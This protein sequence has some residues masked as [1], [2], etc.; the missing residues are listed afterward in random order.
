MLK[1][2]KSQN[3]NLIKTPLLQLGKAAIAKG[4][5]DYLFIG[6]A[7]S[8]PISLPLIAGLFVAYAGVHYFERKGNVAK[9]KIISDEF[10]QRFDEIRSYLGKSRKTQISEL[11]KILE[12]K[13]KQ[14]KLYD[15]IAYL[16]EETNN[17][18]T[19]FDDIFK[20]INLLKSDFNDF[21]IQLE[22]HLCLI[23]KTVE[24]I[25]ETTSRTELKIDNS[26]KEINVHISDEINKLKDFIGNEFSKISKGTATNINAPFS[27]GYDSQMAEQLEKIKQ[28]ETLIAEVQVNKDI[29]HQNSKDIQDVSS[30]RNINTQTNK[31]FKEKSNTPKNIFELFN[32][33]KIQMMYRNYIDAMELSEGL[34]VYAENLHIDDVTPYIQVLLARLTINCFETGVVNNKKQLGKAK[35]LLDLAEKN[36]TSD[37]CDCID[38]LKAIVIEFNGTGTVLDLLKDKIN[39]YA[40]RAR[41]ASLTANKKYSEAIKLIEEQDSIHE[42]WSEVALLAYVCDG[43]ENKAEQ[44]LEEIKSSSN[45]SLFIICSVKYAEILSLKITLL[46]LTHDKKYYN[47]IAEKILNLL[48][49]VLQ[50]TAYS[51]NIQGVFC[52]ANEMALKAHFIKGN[53]EEIKKYSNLLLPQTPV[54]LVVLESIIRQYIQS[55]PDILTRIR[56]EHKNNINAQ[57]LAVAIQLHCLNEPAE[58]FIAFKKVVSLAKTEHEKEITI[59]CLL[60]LWQN[61]DVELAEDCYDLAMNLSEPNSLSVFKF[62]AGRYLRNNQPD[63]VLELLKEQPETDPVILQ[64]KGNAYLQKKQFSDAGVY[65]RKTAELVNSAE[66]Y[67]K[68]GDFYLQ[69]NIEREAI[70]CYEKSISLQP[71]NIV[72]R[73]NLAD[74]YTRTY[75]DLKKAIEHLLALNELKP[76]DSKVLINIAT[77]YGRLFEAEKSLKYYDK[78]CEVD[79]PMLE[80]V[81][82]KAELLTMIKR[83]DEAFTH[84]EFFKELFQNDPDFLLV[85]MNA[86]HY[87]GF[88]DKA[89]QVMKVIID[90]QK[91]GKINEEIIQKFP[92]DELISMVKERSQKANETNKNIHDKML[93]GQFPWLWAESIN[94]NKNFYWGWRQRTQELRWRIETPVD[95]ASF[96]IYATNGFHTQK[97][98]DQ[99]ISLLPIKCPLANTTIV[100]DISALIT[101]QQLNLLDTTIAY[102]DKIIIPEEYLEVVLNQGKE[103]ILHQK[104]LYIAATQIKDCLD[105]GNISTLTKDQLKE[106]IIKVD[107]YYTESTE[108]MYHI[109]DIVE[110]LFASGALEESIYND[111]LK[112]CS[113]PQMLKD[114]NLLKYRQRVQ[115]E[116]STLK[117]FANLGILKQM[118]GFYDIYISSED[119]NTNVQT[120]RSVEQQN[121]AIDKYYELWRRLKKEPKVEFIRSN[122][123][124]SNLADVDI[125]HVVLSTAL[126]RQKNCP[127]MADDRV[128]QALVFN[129]SP[130]VL[131]PVFGTDALILGLMNSDNLSQKDS[132]NC[133]LTLMQWRYRFIVLPPELL[134]EAAL[135]YLEHPPGKLLKQIAEYIQDCMRDPGLFTGNE[136]TELD[137]SMAIRLYLT[138]SANIAKFIAHIWQDEK[139]DQA[140][141]EKFTNWAINEFLPSPPF[142]FNGGQKINVENSTPKQIIT[143]LLLETWTLD[144][145]RCIQNGMEFIK[146]CFELTDEEYAKIIMDIL[147]IIERSRP[148]NGSKEA[149]DVHDMMLK[150]MMLIAFSPTAP[151]DIRTFILLENLNLNEQKVDPFGEGIDPEILI[152]IN[153]TS[154]LYL[155]PGPLLAYCPKD[156]QGSIIVETKNLFCSPILNIRRAIF[157]YYEQAIATKDL[158]ITPR[159]AHVLKTEQEKIL[160]QENEI[161]R[162]ASIAI[163]DALKE[164]FFISLAG[165]NQVLQTELEIKNFLESY[166]P[167][168]LQPKF[169][170]MNSIKL[171]FMDPTMEHDNIKIF[172]NKLSKLESLT[173]VCQSYYDKLGH[174]PLAAKFSLGQV[175][176]QWQKK[177]RVTQIWDEVWLWADSAFGPIP[178]YHACTVFVLFPELVPSNKRSTLWHKIESVI[179]DSVIQDK[180]SSLCEAWKL[181][182]DLN[183]HFTFYLEAN[184]P[185]ANGAAIANLTLWLT[186]KISTLFTEKESSISFYRKEWVKWALEQSTN[187]WTVANPN[188]TESPLRYMNHV[189]TSPWSVSLLGLMGD[190][191]EK[192]RP[193]NISAKLKK[194]LNTTLVHHLLMALPFSTHKPKNATYAFQLS[195]TNTIN[196]WK[197]TQ[198]LDQVKSYNHLIKSNKKIRNNETFID[199]FKD[200]S[201][202]SLLDQ[203]HLVV[204]L[205]HKVFTNFSIEDT[206]IPVIS[207]LNWRDKTLLSIDKNVLGLLVEALIILQVKS[208][209]DWVFKLPHYL[210]ELCEKTEDEELLYSLFSYVIYTSLA[211]DS[212]SSIRRLIQSKD[213]GKYIKYIENFRQQEKTMQKDYPPWVAGK[214]RSLMTAMNIY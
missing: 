133:F 175:V 60:E 34:N 79:S 142:A 113:K 76:N 211:V 189:L 15:L 195:L 74:S 170:S 28:D 101:L 205:K 44:I 20:Q 4:I 12:I 35:K 70:G 166:V 14:E 197:K 140:S 107:E 97:G 66:M 29:S 39:P 182:K 127:L 160:S 71:D 135:A 85:Y 111:T 126:A 139:I 157:T 192:L 165:V 8:A 116:L 201:D 185:G 30:I 55:P 27:G 180:N 106:N 214:L 154:R 119:N 208:Q 23:K 148:V 11:S 161:W 164:D 36:A 117:T 171:D 25:N 98:Y 78:A 194:K 88:D 72:A 6:T 65:F 128:L 95:W 45:H 188:E 100:A 158:E 22:N 63:K 156:K 203:M 204:A 207:D 123:R 131:F 50:E 37:L 174:C 147:N 1:K 69:A 152:N 89:N 151:I 181:R 47:S 43:E 40:I 31:K 114:D 105:N 209:K 51:K 57:V 92:Q 173:D 120:V 136:K 59:N 112:V 153:H 33:I 53:T 2:D 102:F 146:I 10:E 109:R 96:T 52:I 7:A 210:A 150:R 141:T 48:A 163:Y 149:N 38:A 26:K 91:K 167:E 129:E 183:R 187:I 144:D 94:G 186:E 213:A 198:P 90:L 84:L 18:N 145:Y 75:I 93:L 130:D 67:H 162:P 46:N 32:K 19:K 115:I 200:I 104:S 118:C 184:F 16:K 5:L 99:R 80:A 124:E 159:T 73:S 193:E 168:I 212:F 49:P 13:L 199:E 64:M 138:W 41:L 87:A 42:Y 54:P 172:I 196:K 121:D 9:Q 83:E 132:L 56:D 177:N 122:R 178:Q 137:E 202:S 143:T 191:L 24:T 68:A 190:K 176:K 155:P 81:A 179:C 17:Q 77:C 62:K 86:A 3:L 110:S 61:L 21:K 103:I 134:K 206:I 125:E 82:G 169:T 58:A 108:A